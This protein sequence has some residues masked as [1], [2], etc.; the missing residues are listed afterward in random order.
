M[1]YV[2]LPRGP[3]IFADKNVFTG[4]TNINQDLLK[5]L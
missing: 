1:Q 2:S 4:P 5:N 3:N